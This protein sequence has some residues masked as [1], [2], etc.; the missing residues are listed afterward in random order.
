MRLFTG[1]QVE[2]QAKCIELGFTGLA[3]AQTQEDK[4]F[5]MQISLCEFSI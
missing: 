4:E 5:M 3:E 2:A 1:N